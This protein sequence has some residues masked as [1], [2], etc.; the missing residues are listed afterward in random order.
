MAGTILP[1]TFIVSLFTDTVSIYEVD[2]NGNWYDVGFVLGIAL[3]SG[4]VVAARATVLTG[5]GQPSTGCGPT[6]SRRQRPVRRTTGV[7]G[8]SGAQL[9][10]VSV[11]DRATR[12]RAPGTSE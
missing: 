8:E 10:A 9:P 2:N 11:S 7:R 12:A 3:F 4:P 1:V 5:G 6:S